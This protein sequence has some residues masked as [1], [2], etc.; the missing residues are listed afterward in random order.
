MKS[1]LVKCPELNRTAVIEANCPKDA[2]ESFV[3]LSIP[4]ETALKETFEI[5]VVP[6]D[7]FGNAIG[8]ALGQAPTKWDVFAQIKYTA[9]SRG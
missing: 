8:K 3:E 1:Y 7:K 2:A 4:I 6:T 9:I 5:F